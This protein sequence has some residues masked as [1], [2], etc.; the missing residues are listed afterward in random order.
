MLNKF[1]EY[2]NL[3]AWCKRH[4]EKSLIKVHPANVPV[5]EILE[6]LLA[7]M[8]E[9]EVQFVELESKTGH[10]N[11]LTSAEIEARDCL[12]IGPLGTAPLGEVKIEKLPMP[13]HVEVKIENL[14]L[15]RKKNDKPNDTKSGV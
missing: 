15:K 3:E 2:P 7:R 13:S 9:L 14:P 4:H 8:H 1:A 10:A 12:D 6:E 11:F 5:P